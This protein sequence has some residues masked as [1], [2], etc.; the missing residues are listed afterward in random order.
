MLKGARIDGKLDLL[1]GK[2]PFP[3]YFE[4]SA[5]PESIDLRKADIGALYLGGTHTGSINA[6]G[7]KTGGDVFLDNGFR[8]EG[9]VLLIGAKIGGNFQ[10]ANGQF[11]NKGGVTLN[12]DRIMV[13]GS[14]L[15]GDGFRSEGEV[16]LV[17]ATIGGVLA[18]YHGQFINKKGKALNADSLNVAGNV[19]LRTGFKA[20]GEVS[21][22]GA[23]IGGNLDCYDGRFTN[24]GAVALN[25]DAVKV[26]GSVFLRDGFRAEGDTR[27][28]GARIG[29]DLA[30]DNGKF[31]NKGAIALSA[32]DLKAE[33]RVFLRGDFKAEGEVRLAGTVI[34][35]TFDCQNG[36]FIN[37]G[38][39]ALGADRVKVEGDVFLSNGFSAEG[40]VHLVGA[41]IAGDLDCENARFINENAKSFFADGLRV[42]R[43]LRMCKG[44]RASGEVSLVSATIN[45]FFYWMRVQSPEE[46]TL[47]LRSAK[48]GTL[49]D[50]KQSWPEKGK[51]LLHGLVYDEIHN[52][53]P[54]DA[55][56]RI[57]WVRRQR[58][59]YPQPYEQLAAVLRKSGDDA[60]AKRILIAKNKDKTRLTKLT[61]SECVWYR[62]FG[63][64]IDYGYRPWRA[65]WVGLV[66]VLLGWVCFSA[67]YRA[68]VITPAKENT[69]ASGGFC[70]LVYSLDVFVPLVDLR[71]AEYWLPNANRAGELHISEKLQLPVSGKVLRYYLWFEIIAGWV[72]T[73]LLVVG[74]TGLVRT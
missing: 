31:I 13:E 24:T 14:V 62:L 28:V 5:L 66:L 39:R 51:L 67:G 1:F 33:G 53:A 36:Q 54:R 69:D 56:T 2:I 37:K 3:L 38:G 11:I 29:G 6:D 73:T 64:I 68:E 22:I 45:R 70:A 47:D 12:A 65:A 55:K 59:F 35:V 20:D 17:N 72:L 26:D 50:E 58:A 30:C 15:L 21:L 61:W 44:F 43:N 48:L 71:Q 41:T 9:L 42:R 25:A 49:R 34:G 57:D 60:G 7:L 23:R 19:F 10:C 52:T 4:K 46:V 63:P 8:A 27:L 18:C 16:R 40:G 32:S 74:L